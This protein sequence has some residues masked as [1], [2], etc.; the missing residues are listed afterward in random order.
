VSR[1]PNAF[2]PPV[3]P[4]DHALAAIDASY[5]MAPY[6]LGPDEALVMRARWPECR[7]AS[8]SLW[9]RHM[10]TFDYAHRTVA[11]NR[12][13]TVLDDDG[14]FRAV[15][16]HRDPG[17]PNWLDTEGRAKGHTNGRWIRPAVEPEVATKV[18]KFADIRSHLPADHPVVDEQ[19]RRESLQRRRFAYNRWNRR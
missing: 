7:C 15:I 2:P 18:V 8:V 1:E 11:L 9:N 4:A 17:V 19:A 5:S 6:V 16:A 10:Q 14:T 12:A 3:P 13:Q